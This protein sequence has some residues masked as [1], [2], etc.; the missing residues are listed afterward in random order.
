MFAAF[1]ARVWPATALHAYGPVGA[2]AE[3]NGT[4]FADLGNTFRTTE[5]AT[6]VR[7]WRVPEDNTSLGRDLTRFHPLVEVCPL[8]LSQMNEKLSFRDRLL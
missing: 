5:A 8:F 1:G 6:T 3:T 2:T 4:E 7:Q